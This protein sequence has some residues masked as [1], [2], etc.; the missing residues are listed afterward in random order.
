MH[1]AT[2]QIRAETTRYM[3][4]TVSFPPETELV[5]RKPS[6]EVRM[7]RRL[8]IASVGLLALLSLFNLVQLVLNTSQSSRAAVGGMK[9]A[10]L[11]R[12]PGFAHAV[13]SIVQEC[14][15]NVD[16]GVVKC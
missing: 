9:Y 3:D 6:W 14:K 13:K 7:S 1:G 4:T 10:D 11:I 12:D 5:Q 2:L 8:V 15:V 16:L